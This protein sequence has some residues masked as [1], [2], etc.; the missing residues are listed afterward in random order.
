MSNSLSDVSLLIGQNAADLEL[1]RDVF[2]TET[3]RFV[4]G[5]LESI[6]KA[7]SDPWTSGRV[8]VDLPREIETESKVAAYFSNQYALARADLRFK[9]GTKFVVVAEIPF[10]FTFDQAA[11]AF[12][13]QVSV[14]P[15]ARYAR[16]D[17]A[18]WRAW[19][20]TGCSLP[21]A[22]HQ[23]R[24]NTV[25]FVSRP[26]TKDVTLELVFADLKTVL[27]FL[28]TAADSLAE[29]VGVDLT[30]AEEEST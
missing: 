1:A 27:E 9:K 14:V 28:L 4:E 3:R 11:N 25:R 17:D 22:I 26:V 2:T 18:I 24:A 6:R 7:R 13:W 16:L 19:R 5:V 29:A 30:P 23:E 10:G 15:A 21:G 12:A 20:G 8:R